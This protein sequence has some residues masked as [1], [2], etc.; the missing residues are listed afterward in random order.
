MWKGVWK[1]CKTFCR[2]AELKTGYVNI[3]AGERNE[4]EK[5]FLDNGERC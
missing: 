5:I 1:V 3:K 2:A 4:R